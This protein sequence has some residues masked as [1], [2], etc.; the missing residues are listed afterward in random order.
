MLHNDKTNGR[1]KE[2]KSVFPQGVRERL[3]TS[4]PGIDSLRKKKGVNY[5]NN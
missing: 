2:G 3:L 4:D 1:I 5:G